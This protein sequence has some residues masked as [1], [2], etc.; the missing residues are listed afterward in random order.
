MNINGICN[1]H[2]PDRLERIKIEYDGSDLQTF[3]DNHAEWFEGQTP[4]TAAEI[5]SKSA[6][7]EQMV[8][9]S[10]AA[11]I[12]DEQDEIDTRGDVLIKTFINKTPQQLSDYIDSKVSDPELNKILKIMLKI[13]WVTSRKEFK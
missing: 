9:D 13:Q 3:L 2:F 11:T 5:E 1:V 8:S 7:Y 12:A 10:Q 6:E 4:I